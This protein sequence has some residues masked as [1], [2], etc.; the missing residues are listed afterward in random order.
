MVLEHLDNPKYAVEADPRS[1]GGQGWTGLQDLLNY[2]FWQSTSVNIFDQS[3]HLLNTSNFVPGECGTLEDAKAI[4]A[5]PQLFKD[6][7][8]NLGPTVPGFNA[9]DPSAAGKGPTAAGPRR[10][11]RL[12][13][14]QR[15]A[16]AGAGGNVS[17]AGAGQGGGA[18]PGSGSGSLWLPNLKDILPGAGAGGGVAGTGVTAPSLPSVTVPGTGVGRGASGPSGQAGV[19]TASGGPAN[20]GGPGHLLEYLMGP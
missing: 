14:Q 16:G 20:D 9:P 6:C 12:R 5:N 3:E 17:G 7:G 1:P 19:G 13:A 11:A 18:K 4:R 2:V 15:N 8:N 10:L